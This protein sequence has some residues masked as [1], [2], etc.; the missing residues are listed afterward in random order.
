[1]VRFAG[2][3]QC[4]RSPVL[5]LGLALLA[6]C[7]DDGQAIDSAM[8]PQEAPSEPGTSVGA[9]GPTQDVGVDRAT[10]EG[11]LPPLAEGARARLEAIPFD[12]AP[13]HLVRDTHYWIS[14][15]QSHFLW[16]E[17]V[18]DRGGV[19]VGV[20]T[21]QNYLLAGWTRP[22]LMIL[23][24]FDGSITELHRVYVALFR[25]AEDLPSFLAYW[26]EGRDIEVAELLTTQLPADQVEGAMEAYRQARPLVHD[27][28][29]R[30]RGDYASRGI[31]TW[32][33][34][35]DTFGHLRDLARQ[36][37]IVPIRGDLG[38]EQ[39]MVEIGRALAELGFE[40]SVVYLSNAEQYLRYSPRFRRN[41]AA[42]PL[43]AH[44]VVLRTHG[45]RQFQYVRDE[46]Y[47]YNVQTGPSFVA[48]LTTTSTTSV[49][50]MLAR[51]QP[52]EI[53][54]LSRLDESPA[55]STKRPRIAE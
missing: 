51:R 37:R 1:M 9:G 45:W 15:E 39:T 36:G 46:E 34:D 7:A 48:W 11:S 16:Y 42:L 55:P 31:P 23:M 24:D 26:D 32:V 50:P 54:G 3:L 29:D 21:D 30:V 53:K 41:L 4:S 35:P 10:G 43:A 8:L 20:G 19:Y 6:G 27:R 38:G 44:S 5:V 2:M 17:T 13:R 47:H 14:N 28:I 52:S 25:A 12:P 22:E 18:L 33:T 49:A 40:V